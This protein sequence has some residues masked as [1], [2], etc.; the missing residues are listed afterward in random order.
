MH[1]HFQRD[2]VELLTKH[3]MY[4]PRS[5]FVDGIAKPRCF[6]VKTMVWG[7]PKPTV[8]GRNRK[9]RG[10]RVQRSGNG[11]PNAFEPLPPRDAAGGEGHGEGI[12]EMPA[13]TATLDRVHPRSVKIGRFSKYS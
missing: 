6:P 8:W 3:Y 11:R 5:Y 2:L 9:R 1:E 12:A 7:R 13:G 4:T 10:A